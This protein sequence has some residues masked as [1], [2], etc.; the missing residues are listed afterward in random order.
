MCVRAKQVFGRTPQTL[1]MSLGTWKVRF[2][3]TGSLLFHWGVCSPSSAPSVPCSSKV[4][5]SCPSSHA[6]LCTQRLQWSVTH[7]SLSW[8][9]SNVWNC[10]WKRNSG[11]IFPIFLLIHIYICELS[12]T[13]CSCRVW[14][15]FT[16]LLHDLATEGKDLM[17]ILYIWRESSAQMWA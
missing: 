8:T 6:S 4:Y 9:V 11:P 12:V 10:P 13:P 7:K 1:Y 2:D 14:V 15:F 16:F 5:Q 17:C 3:L